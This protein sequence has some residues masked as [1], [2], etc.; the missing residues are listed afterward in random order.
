MVR[1]ALYAGSWY[2][3]DPSSLMALVN[4]SIR[5]VSQEPTFQKGPYRFGVLPH[6]GLLYSK[7]GIAPFFVNS[8]ENVKRIVVISPSHYADIGQDEL[9]SAPLSGC[10]TPLGQVKTFDLE[11][12]DA[13]WFSAV[14]AEHALEMVLPFIAARAFDAQVALSLIS[15]FSST[16]AIERAA[17]TLL[18]D[19]GEESVADGST[20]LLASSD[21]THY[22][23]RFGYTPYSNSV[24]Q[25]V[26]ED[27]LSLSHMLCE[28]NI[29]KALNFCMQ[30]RS[31]VC[32]Y[33]PALLVSYL[34]GRVHAK[35]WIANYYTS[36]DISSQDANFVAYCTI[37]WR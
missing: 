28:G 32:G 18:D 34:A 27:D 4:A 26:K 14:Q 15:R 22:G 16:E 30:K 23:P 36:Q 6:A 5:Q 9:V 25:K 33:A 8:L 1:Q 24:S 17:D 35:G 2:P 20:V 7:S 29:E 37:L 10:E 21:F 3:N 11:N 19:L 12:C 13:T 31:T